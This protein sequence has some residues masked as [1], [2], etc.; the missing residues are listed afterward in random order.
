MGRRELEDMGGFFDPPALVGGAVERQRCGG[1]IWRR[2][3]R[4]S[5]R[6]PGAACGSLSMQNRLLP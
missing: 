2:K 4:L 3:N 1:R 6:W 5:F